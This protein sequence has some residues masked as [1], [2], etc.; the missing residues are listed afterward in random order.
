[1]LP[2]LSEL[3]IEITQQCP[4]Q[5][6]FC[7][8]S[9]SWNT[10]SHLAFGNIVYAVHQASCLGLRQVYL[11]GGEPL[12]HPEFKNIIS[13]LQAM[14]VKPIV[15]TSGI[16][17]RDGGFIAFEDWHK[18]SANLTVIFNVPSRNPAV[19]DS[20]VRHRGAHWLTM[21][22][23]RTAIE[24]RLRTE[25]HIIP[26]SLNFDSLE[27]DII[28]FYQLGVNRVSFLRLVDQG[29]AHQ[30]IRE[31]KLKPTQ[32]GKLQYI[33][34]WLQMI[35]PETRL[36][37]PFTSI[38]AK[39]QSCTAGCGKLVIRYDGK[40]FPCEA[41]KNREEFSLGDYRIESLEELLYKAADHD[42]LAVLKARISESEPC[43]AQL[44]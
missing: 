5:C 27:A 16:V 7:S 6:L 42:R 34:Q 23:L 20:L 35:Y 37:I 39:H 43:P 3:T 11:S 29:N 12:V 25:V 30:F 22:S 36:G 41:F 15:Y 4:N 14:G 28:H 19:H 24:A 18:F 10:P 17:H 33:C 9:S 40:V 21:R 2:Q 26:N 38:A 13:A 31:L 32:Q 8:S 1:M 44:F